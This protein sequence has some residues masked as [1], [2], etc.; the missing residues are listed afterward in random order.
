LNSS[1]FFDSLSKIR[2]SNSL[3]MA[4]DLLSNHLVTFVDFVGLL[5]QCLGLFSQIFDGVGMISMSQVQGIE[6]FVIQSIS[7]HHEAVGS[8]FSIFFMSGKDVV[9]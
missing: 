6:K 3:D 7:P 9:V 1:W 5:Q 8:E 4:L 2:M